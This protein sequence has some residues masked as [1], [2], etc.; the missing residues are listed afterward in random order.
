MR[1][2]EE[3]E[4]EVGEGEKRKNTQM[5]SSMIILLKNDQSTTA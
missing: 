3:K 4:E 1:E 2:R 5:K